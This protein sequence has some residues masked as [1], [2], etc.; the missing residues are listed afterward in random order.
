MATGH[1]THQPGRSTPD[2]FTRF[3]H[4][5][6]AMAFLGAWLTA[7][8]DG[9]RAWHIAFGHILAGALLLRVAWSLV[10]PRASLKRWWRTAAGAA[11]RLFSRRSSRAGVA[12]PDS[13]LRLATWSLLGLAALVCGALVLVP[14]CFVSGW[15]LSRLVDAPAGPLELHRWLGTA[16]MVVVA[17]HVAL[18]A[19]LG[20]LRGRCM[21][22]DMLPWGAARSADSGKERG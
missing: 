19:V 15:A 2:L 14:G 13:P 3:T 21:A 4:A 9:L 6:M 16:L 1:R 20:V 10:R 5:L 11:R 8:W 17:A 12:E 18:V 7:E 22:C